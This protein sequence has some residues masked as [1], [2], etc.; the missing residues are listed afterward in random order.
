MQ[1]ERSVLRP[2][3][4]CFTLMWENFAQNNLYKFPCVA[5]HNIFQIFI[6]S[7]GIPVMP[8]SQLHL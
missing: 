6:A 4:E 7:V 1:L 5:V 2:Y 8:P 3:P